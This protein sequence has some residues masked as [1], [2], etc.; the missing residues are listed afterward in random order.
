MFVVFISL[1]AFV[2]FF[3]RKLFKPVLF[4]AGVVLV[5]SLSWLIFYSTFLN[6]STKSWVGWV[7]LGCSVL[8]GLCV[9]FLF[10]KVAKLGAFILAAWGGFSLGLLVYNAF[11]YKFFN[12]G[13]FWG[14]ICG[15]ALL[16]GILALFF[17]DH[18]L[19]HSTA[20]AGAFLFIQAIGLVAGGYQNPFTIAK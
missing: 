16:F 8:V 4:I 13:G 11:L 5:V 10:T 7:V 20:F 15:L 17:F 18:I 1:G 6:T 14:F 3:G 19:I 2:C 9:G 12:V